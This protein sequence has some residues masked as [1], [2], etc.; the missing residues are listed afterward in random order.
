MFNSY[1]CS[2]QKQRLDNNQF[3]IAM[4]NNFL[5]IF[6]SLPLVVGGFFEK[7]CLHSGTFNVNCTMLAVVYFIHYKLLPQRCRS[8]AIQRKIKCS[9]SFHLLINSAQVFLSLGV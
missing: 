2:L 8:F 9:F 1:L 5:A 3:R 7:E 4:K 6:G